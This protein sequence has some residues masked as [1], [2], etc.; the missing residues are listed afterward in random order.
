MVKQLVHVARQAIQR[1]LK[2]GTNEPAIIVRG[3][4]RGHKVELVDTA[5]GKVMGRFIYSPEKPLACGAR[6]WLEM[7]TDTMS[8]RIAA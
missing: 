5:T 2:H 6:C 4:G 8:A 3:T 7:N 1:N